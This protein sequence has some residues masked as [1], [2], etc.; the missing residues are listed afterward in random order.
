VKRH[1]PEQVLQGNALATFFQISAQGRKN[2]LAERLI[3][4][5]VELHAGAFHV[6]RDEQLHIASRILDPAFFQI[7]SACID[8]FQHGGHG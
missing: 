5:Q 3:E 8:A 1:A 4:A 6:M 2:F 7:G